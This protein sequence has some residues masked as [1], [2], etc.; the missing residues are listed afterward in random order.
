MN[1]GYAIEVNTTTADFLCPLCGGWTLAQPG[2]VVVQRP[3]G[4]IVCGACAKRELYALHTEVMVMECDTRTDFP[5]IWLELLERLSITEDP[6]YELGLLLEQVGWQ[7]YT[8]PGHRDRYQPHHPS[9][10]RALG[11]M[12]RPTSVQLYTEAVETK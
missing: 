10:G 9:I 11:T 6:D 1:M 5:D 12:E 8:G 4:D 2:L 7:R 3:S